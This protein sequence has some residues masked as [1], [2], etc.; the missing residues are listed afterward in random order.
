MIKTCGV[1]NFPFLYTDLP[2]PVRRCQTRISFSTLIYV[3]MKSVYNCNRLLLYCFLVLIL[4]C[5]KDAGLPCPRAGAAPPDTLVQPAEPPRCQPIVCGEAQSPFLP[6]PACLPGL[7]C[8]PAS[9]CLTAPARRS[10]P[11]CL[12]LPPCQ[13][14]YQREPG[15]CAP[16]IGQR[17]PG[18]QLPV[19]RPE[20]A[21]EK[22]PAQPA[23][24]HGPCRPA[25]P[26]AQPEQPDNRK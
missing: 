23:F 13:S 25:S 15:C 5:R 2:P 8:R 24:R 6:H 14:A 16:V 10:Q 11:G 21:G 18:C 9:C 26:S 7:P 22:G 12:T 19:P 3:I 4:A 1:V 20:A 17:Q